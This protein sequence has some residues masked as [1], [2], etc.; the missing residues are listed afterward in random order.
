MPFAEL[1]NA[2]RGGRRVVSAVMAEVCMEEGVVGLE[3]RVARIESDVI[4]IK[5][6]VSRLDKRVDRLEDKIDERF[7]RV[8][9]RFDRIDGKVNNLDKRMAVMEHGFGNVI[10]N[11]ATLHI[12][13]REL[14]RSVDSKFVWIV[15]TM[16]AFGAALLV[17][18]AKGFHWLK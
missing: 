5:E 2:G 11:Q 15:T 1:G 13:L 14:R 10:E 7:D 6:T 9:E 8:D 12:D 17:A 16:I 4:N 3:P 18:M